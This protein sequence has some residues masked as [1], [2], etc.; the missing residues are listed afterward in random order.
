VS[1]KEIVTPGKAASELL[2]RT[3]TIKGGGMFGDRPP[4]SQVKYIGEMLT[5]LALAQLEQAQA[6]HRIAAAL[7]EDRA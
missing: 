1:D 6:L 3:Y 7:E 4:P 2:N 5:A